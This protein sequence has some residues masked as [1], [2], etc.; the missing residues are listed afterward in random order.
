MLTLAILGFLHDE[1]LHGYELKSRITGLTGHVRPVSDGALYP[2]I[3]R[4]EKAGLLLRRSEPGSG[5]VPRQVLELT[6]EGR[7]ELERRL[8]EPEQAEI[9]DQIRFFTVAAFLDRLTDPARQAAVLRR[10]LAF[11]EAPSSFFYDADGRPVTAEQ[12]RNPF[13]RGM[14]LV[15][16]A[17]GAAERAWLA[18]TIA[19]LENSPTGG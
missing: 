17:S 15:A 10:R 19:A 3:T 14:L 16:R 12:E 8:A 11:L 7:A 4:L 9:S 13:R 18:E 5:A 2:A 1:P 6:A